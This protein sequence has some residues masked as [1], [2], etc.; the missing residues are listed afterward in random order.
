M[1]LNI[2]SEVIW[3]FYDE[4]RQKTSAQ[5]FSRKDILQY[6]TMAVGSKFYMRYYQAKKL[7]GEKDY[8]FYSADLT[9]KKFPLGDANQRGV[10]RIEFKD[11][12]YITLP[13][14]DDI[15]NAYPVGDN[16]GGPLYEITQ[17][18]PGEENFYLGSEFNS[19]WFFVVKGPGFDFYHIP[20]CVKNIEVERPWITEEMDISLDM[21]Y[22]ISNEILGVTLKVKNFAIKTI[23]NPYNPKPIELKR[24]LEEQQQDI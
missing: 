24:K 21:A 15:T 11:A 13:H 12:Q 5:T 18:S 6:V 23:D 4:G 1:R 20:A 2:I 19:F 3:E 10:R 9:L 16:C 17:V 8:Y 7:D 14:N 22:D